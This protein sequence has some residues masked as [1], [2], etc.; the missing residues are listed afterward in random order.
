MGRRRP[1]N[2]PKAASKPRPADRKDGRIKRWDKRSDIELDEE[3][4]FHESR[5]K[6]L[7][8]G[9]D[10][11]DDDGFG[12]EEVFALQGISDD[13]QGEDN[14]FSEEDGIQ[15]ID[16]E[17]EDILSKKQTTKTSKSKSKKAKKASP[18]PAEEEEEETWGHGK[19]AYYSSNAAQIDS[20]DEEAQ[21]LEEQEARRLQI[22]ARDEMRDDDFGL[23]EVIEGDVEQE[24]AE[25]ALEVSGPTVQDVPRDKQSLLR[26]LERENPEAIAL[27]RDWDDTARTLME[28]KARIEALKESETDAMELGLQHMHYQALLTYTTTLAFY[29]YMRASDKYATRPQLLRSHPILKRILTLKRS[30]HMLENIGVGQ[31]TSNESG[32]D[33]NEDE[34]EDVED[35]LGGGGTLWDRIKMQLESDELA[36]LI[37]DAEGSSPSPPSSPRSKSPKKKSKSSSAVADDSALTA[38]L[39]SSD[40]KP[41]R[42]KRKTAVDAPVFD[43]I[44]PD[45]TSTSSKKKTKHNS[46][47]AADTS[48]NLIDSYGEATALSNA[49]ENDKQARKKSLRF[50]VSRIESSSSRRQNARANAL[51]GD[52]DIPYRER[53]KERE[54]RLQKERQ[55]RQGEKLGMGGDDLDDIDPELGGGHNDIM[56]SNVS[57]KSKKRRRTTMED[58]DDDNG[59][60]R[61]D[62]GNDALRYYDLVKT[63]VAH[64]KAKKKADYEA[65]VAASRPEF[66][67][68][69]SCGPRSV[70]RDILKNK[71]LTPKR[72]KS[73]RNPRVKKRLKYDKAT[74]KVASQRAVYKGGIGDVSK[75]EGER[76]GISK[77]IKS[78]ALG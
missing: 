24:D 35:S 45:F 76:S 73:V 20:D 59:G 16:T 49:D 4:Q 53:K 39:S 68:D 65:A 61:D 50:H 5:D 14:A 12:E 72:P 77:V 1:S 69:I 60:E 30:L 40:A 18:Q 6:I 66:E 15:D 42:K 74:K 7:L 51:G 22:R 3:D 36:E 26:F 75:Y 23:G 25:E 78:I 48:A 33:G 21:E 43:L 62:Q 55:Q 8:D 32:D 34:D 64:K 2:K 67:D 44:E 31:N 54:A 27:A 17:D 58:G 56:A 11:H 70:T 28:T 71:G 46:K 9:D 29:L 13:E 57:H 52:D 47:I 37:K 63:A 41:P 19:H 10:A 38:S